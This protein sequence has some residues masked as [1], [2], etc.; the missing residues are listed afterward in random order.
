MLF[1]PSWKESLAGAKPG[2][3]RFFPSMEG[4][5][6]TKEMNDFS[7]QPVGTEQLLVSFLTGCS[8]I[9]Y[10]NMQGLEQ[11]WNNETTFSL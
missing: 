5:E 10:G 3:Q 2:R 6:S 8:V 7:E 1:P 11:V 4:R 9:K